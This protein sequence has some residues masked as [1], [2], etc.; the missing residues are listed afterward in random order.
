MRISP[1]NID[2][3]VADDAAVN[4]A[5]RQTA[6]KRSGA[7][8]AKAPAESRGPGQRGLSRVNSELNQQLS[9]AQQAVAFLDQIETRLQ[10]LKADLSA[11]LAADQAAGAQA[12]EGK[13][14]DFSEAWNKRQATA[15]GSLDG[16][17]DFDPAGEA[18]QNFRIRG[19]DRNA[20]QSGDKESL[21]FSVG[22][23]GQRL[24]V[25]SI[26][27]GLSEEALVRRFDQALA[28]ADIR[29]RGD[30]QGGL[31]FSVGESAWPAVRDSLSVKGAGKRFP[32]GQLVQVK[33]DEMPT[34]IRPGSWGSDGVEARRRTLQQV[35]EALGKVRQARDAVNRALAEMGRRVKDQTVSADPDWAEAFAAD[36]ANLAV[37]PVYQV[38]SAIAPA[39]VSI[40]RDRVL[41][42][43]TLR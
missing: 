10:G 24:L 6:G 23:I 28:P 17:L 4:E 33:T 35:V 12:L 32:S 18:R 9:R 29:V 37:Q 43:L 3:P 15:G 7:A 5:R 40:S 20:L 41:A 42:L 36:F 22:G 27:P 25:V 2:R 34:A 13:L 38:Y 1:L 16:Q 30:G 8:P 39:I 14:R 11:N 26:E 19:L 21:A 31:T